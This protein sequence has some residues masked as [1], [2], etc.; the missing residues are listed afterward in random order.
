[1][2]WS[3][4]K[5]DFLICLFL[6]FLGLLDYHVLLFYISD[7]MAENMKDKLEQLEVKEVIVSIKEDTLPSSSVEDTCTVHI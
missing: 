4:S 2:Q 1:M 6:R 3:T 7:R 5:Y